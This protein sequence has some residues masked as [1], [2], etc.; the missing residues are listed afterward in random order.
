VLAGNVTIPL[1]SAG[2]TA[3][4]TPFLGLDYAIGR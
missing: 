4:I 3:P 2:L 1:T